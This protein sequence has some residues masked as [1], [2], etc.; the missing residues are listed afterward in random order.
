[1]SNNV[2]DGFWT[3]LGG[4]GCGVRGGRRIGGQGGGVL[5]LFGGWFVCGQRLRVREKSRIS[6][7]T[8]RGV[9]L[10]AVGPVVDLFAEADSWCQSASILRGVQAVQD[11]VLQVLR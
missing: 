5:L 4:Q 2:C 10:Q 3:G 7:L 11:E 6:S 1:M 8:D 9:V